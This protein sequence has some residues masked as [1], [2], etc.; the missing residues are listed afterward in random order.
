MPRY[1]LASRTTSAPV[2]PLGL[3]VGPLTAAAAG[4][5][6]RAASCA[7]NPPSAPSTP[8]PAAT[9]A[10]DDALVEPVTPPE[11]APAVDGVEPARTWTAGVGSS[12]SRVVWISE[13]RLV[14][15]L[16]L[17]TSPRPRG[18]VRRRCPSGRRPRAGRAGPARA[19]ARRGAARPA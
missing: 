11:A 9:S 7:A 10:P 6:V 4:E 2:G 8:S 13:M 19:A 16:M 5:P 15:A 12:E 3:L 17:T 18:R 14:T 1:R